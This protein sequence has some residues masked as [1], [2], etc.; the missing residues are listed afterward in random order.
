MP[1]PLQQL[2]S[3][4]QSIW[5]DFIS[6]KTLDDGIRRLAE[7]WGNEFVEITRPLEEEPGCRIAWVAQ[8]NW[9]WS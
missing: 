1:N 5:L 8:L 2:P 7:M 3:F 9:L 4:G 6:R